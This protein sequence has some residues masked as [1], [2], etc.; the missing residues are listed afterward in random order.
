MRRM[1]QGAAGFWSGGQAM[2][3]PELCEQFDLTPEEI[4]EAWLF[5]CFLRFKALLN[6]DPLSLAQMPGEII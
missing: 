5:L 6:L 1:R 4:R 3:F 2:T